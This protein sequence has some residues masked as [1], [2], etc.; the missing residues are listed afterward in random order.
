MAI[1]ACLSAKADGVGHAPDD[2]PLHIDHGQPRLL[3]QAALHHR[4]ADL[5]VKHQPQTDGQQELT[6]QQLLQT[7]RL[8]GLGED[9]IKEDDEEVKR[10]GVLG[11]T[12]HEKELVEGC[13]EA[14]PTQGGATRAAY[15]P[16]DDA[17][18]GA[19]AGE[20]DH[21]QPLRDERRIVGQ[22]VAQLKDEE[23]RVK[24]QC[25]GCGQEHELVASATY[26]PP[27]DDKPD[28]A[29]G[30]GD[31]V[32]DE[33]GVRVV[34]HHQQQERRQTDDL[35]VQAVTYIQ[36]V[37]YACDAIHCLPLLS[38]W[39]W[40]I[41]S[42]RY[43]NNTEAGG[44]VYTPMIYARSSTVWRNKKGVPRVSKTPLS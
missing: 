8:V 21:E 34:Q 12:G 42:V 27:K 14:R 5:L 6:L 15:T 25:D 22:H 41:K 3:G 28:E 35:I 36:A 7:K 29:H 33:V 16:N 37:L 43:R 44:F 18:H 40:A 31:E 26:R 2:V 10:V 39:L 4:E 9:L 24:R 17:L 23:E 20:Y 19:D 32:G 13:A 38:L 11:D 1:V 30:G